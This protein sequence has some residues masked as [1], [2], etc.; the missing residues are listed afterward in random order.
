MLS[1]V[2]HS[3]G[4]C[5]GRAHIMKDHDGASDLPMAVMDRRGRIFNGGFG[6]VS[7]DQDTI[8]C[9]GH[10]LVF[11]DCECHRIA[12]LCASDAI[13]DSEYLFKRMTDRFD[14][15]PPG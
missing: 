4:R 10:G 11:S 9:Q 14:V 15:R 2:S 13:N 6:S 1:Q 8:R 7:T 12:R 5:P 3:Q